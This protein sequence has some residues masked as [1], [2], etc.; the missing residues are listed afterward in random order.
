M[1]NLS[2]RLAWPLVLLAI[3]A[4]AGAPAYGQGN[5]TTLSGVVTDDQG[6]V[7]PGADVT[8]KNNATATTIQGVTDGTGRFTLA[9]VAPGTY[10][11]TVALMGFKTAILPDVEVLTGTPASVKVILKVGTLEETVVVTG[12]TEIVQSTSPTVSSTIAVKQIQQL[13][14]ITHTALD[15]VISLPGIQTA[16][17]DT[18]LSTVNG[19]SGTSINITLDGI[20]AQDKRSTEGMF[21]YIRPMMDSV[22]EITVSTSNSDAAATGAGATNIRMETRSGSNRFTGS[23]YNTWRNQAGTNTDDTLKRE[24]SPG[25]LWGLNT[26]YWYNKRDIAKTKAGDYFINDVRLQTPGF[27]V[28]GPIVKDKLF[29]FFNYEEFRL[30]ES[31]SRTRYVLTTAAQAGTFTYDR[32]DGAGKGTVNLFTLA[33]SKG[34]TSTI[35]P[36][37]SKL[38]ADIRTAAASDSSAGYTPLA[39]NVEAWNYSPSAT[40]KRRFPTVRMD[41]NLTNAHRLGFS[42]RYNEF[43]STPDLL[44]SAETRFPGFPNS[45]GQYSQRFMWQVNLRSTLGKSLVNEIRTGKSDAMGEGTYFGKGVSSAQ[46]NCPGLGCQQANGKGYDLSGNTVSNTSVL[47][48]VDGYGLTG[49]SAYPGSSAGVASQT[50]VSD[51]VTWLKGKHSMSFGGDFARTQMR[52]MGTSPTDNYI[53]FGLSTQDT[54][55]YNM[56]LDTS[57]NFPGGITATNA[58]Y[59]RSLYAVLTGRVT[60]IGSTYN[61]QP[62]GTY[63]PYGPTQNGAIADDIGAFFSDS[64]RVKPNLTLTLGARYQVQLPFRGDSLYSKPETWQMVYGIT[65]ANDSGRYGSG[66]LYKPGVMTGTAPVVVKYDNSKPAYNTDWNNISPSVGAAWRPA[67]KEGFLSKLL[68]KDP[69]FRGGYSMTSVR[70]GTNFFDTNYS[71]NPGRTRAG[72]RTTTSGTPFLPISDGNPVL[73]RNASQ[74]DLSAAPAPL[75][76]EWRITPSVTE[77][78]R[79]HYPDWP[80]PQVHQYS[81][82]FQRELGKATALDI[83]YVGNTEVGGWTNW[84]MVSTAQWSMMK[85]ENGWYDEFRLAQA[86]LRANIVAGRGGTTSC[87]GCTFAYYGPGTGTSALPITLAYLKGI[88]LSNTSTTGGNMDPALYAAASEFSNSSWYGNL[89]YYSPSVTGMI[90]TGTNAL[91]NGI[92]TGTGRD[93]NRIAAGLPINFFMANP[94]VAQGNAILATN[95]GNT[96]FNSVQ[97]ELRRRMSAGFLIQGSYVYQFGRQTWSQRSLREDWFYTP[98]TGGMDHAAKANWVYELP[99]GRGK[100]FG[101]GVSALVDGFIGGWEIDGVA[102]IQSGLK[103]NYDGYRLVGMTEEEFAGM[104]K[105]YHVIDPT[106]LDANKNPMDRVY[107]LPQDVIQNSI[108][109][110]YNTTATTATGY[111]NNVMPTGRYLAPA[112]GPDC[113]AYQVG[114]PYDVVCQGTKPAVP[115]GSRRIVTGPMFWKVDMSFVKRIP[116]WKNVRVEAR[117]DLFNIFNTINFNPNFAMGSSVTSWQVTSAAADANASQD[118]GGRV[119]SFGLRVTW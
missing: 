83:R 25:W 48:G 20:N 57:G 65:G 49:A 4:M 15:Y 103:A 30:P 73:L 106:T 64:W 79:I 18:R 32:A 58:G 112:S 77:T 95:G 96:R 72:T 100:K 87:P 107:M 21:M 36:T 61:L 89:N 114:S 8:A 63:L 50:S 1:K 68:S 14:V 118:P 116:V 108:I 93:A 38:L 67:L 82:G 104:F 54:T 56:L 16:G 92:G 33:A 39:N 53:A 17:S 11:V 3:L 102:R 45:A 60:T 111:T 13:P 52:N 59:A 105:Y 9:G 28:G 88:P 37:V 119:T 110:L 42:Y 66:N 26:P 85:G 12:Q 84:N 62:D 43:N 40:Q 99:F 19:L 27:R 101:S 7:V 75:T 24:N 113:A 81:F 91:Q 76:G 10:T 29:Y 34:Q 97:I 47:I 41:Y 2:A 31:R 51:T 86:N 78:V 70:L 71:G 44:N 5:T 55:A 98:S 94:T 6:G 115:G 90:G 23:V 74:M 35:D 117:M 80:V 109:A 69:V 22:E 46:F